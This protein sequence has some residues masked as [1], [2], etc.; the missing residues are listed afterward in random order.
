MEFIVCPGLQTWH[1]PPTLLYFMSHLHFPPHET[2]CQEGAYKPG[3]LAKAYKQ[4]LAHAK[5]MGMNHKAGLGALCL[6]VGFCGQAFSPHS[7]AKWHVQDAVVY[8]RTSRV[9]L[10]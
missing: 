1:T 8:W 10:S 6:N 4:Y 9:R 5:N 3:I 2:A 7:S